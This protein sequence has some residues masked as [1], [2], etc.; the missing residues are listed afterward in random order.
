MSN[1][2]PNRA[3]LPYETTIKV[4]DNCLCLHLQR[5]AR[6]VARHFDEL[7]RPTGL[8]SG[9]FSLLMSLNRPD[10]PTM[11]AVA[12]LLA[13]DRTTLTANLK[14]LERRGFVRVRID[15]NDRRSRRL[16]LS[17]KGRAALLAAMPAWE[18]GHALIE[19]ALAGRNANRLRADLR[20]LA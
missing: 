17:A 15:R 2:R 20:A 4:R 12:E 7:M 9:Q 13:M 10:P 14:P 19:P 5:A 1:R 11:R 18:Q 3:P 6:A 8:T 16:V